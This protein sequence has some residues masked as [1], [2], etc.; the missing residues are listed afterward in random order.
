MKISSNM[1][2]QTDR[3][4]FL[5]ARPMQDLPVAKALFV[6]AKQPSVGE[7]ATPVNIVDLE[8]GAVIGRGN[9]SHPA[10]GPSAMSL[11]V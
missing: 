1:Q 2:A 9:A 7:R 8:S 11:Y 3:T 6:A 5:S 4:L 10:P